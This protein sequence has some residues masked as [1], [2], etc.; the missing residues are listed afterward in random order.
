MAK[1]NQLLAAL[2]L[3]ASVIFPV[4]AHKPVHKGPTVA[5]DGEPVGQEIEHN[6]RE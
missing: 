3:G 2:P 5:H 6:N 4:S 1:Y